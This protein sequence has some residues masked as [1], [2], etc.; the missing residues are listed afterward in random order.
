MKLG[1]AAR[2]ATGENWLMPRYE[3]YVVHKER[4]PKWLEKERDALVTIMTRA[5]RIRT[6]TLSASGAGRCRRERQFAY[7]GKPRRKL[8][9][10]G[11]NIFANGDYMHLRHQVAGLVAGYLTEA[12]YFVTNS[13][14]GLTGT[15]DG[16]TSEGA[17][18]EFK[19]INA[20]GYQSVTTWGPKREH[21]EQVHSYMLLTGLDTA[22]ILYENKDTQQMKEFRIDRDPFLMDKVKR[23][24]DEIR[25]A[26]DREELL[27]MLPECTEQQGAWRWCDYRDIC[28]LAR[29]V[30]GADHQKKVVIKRA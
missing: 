17:I 16:I 8:E 6:N 22:W 28:P 27:P 29:F 7:L 26:N 13:E 30:A 20:R 12:E 24:L 19:S 3:D 4:D 11:A 23:E 2:L 25:R 18:A 14:W 15:V 9:P 10:K 5:E 21:E 1:E